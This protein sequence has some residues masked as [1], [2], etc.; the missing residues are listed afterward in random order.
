MPRLSEFLAVRAGTWG[1]EGVYTWRRGWCVQG[2]GELLS[3]WVTRVGVRPVRWP[4][5]SGGDKMWGSLMAVGQDAEL[6]GWGRAVR[7]LG[8]PCPQVAHASP[9]THLLP[10]LPCCGTCVRH[11]YRCPPDLYAFLPGAVS[12]P[13]TPHPPLL[14]S[15]SPHP[16]DSTCCELRTVDCVDSFPAAQ[17]VAPTA[18]HPA[19]TLAHIHHLFAYRHLR[20]RDSLTPYAVSF[21][22]Y[23]CPPPLDAPAPPTYPRSNPTWWTA[24]AP[25]WSAAAG[26][27]G[28]RCSPRA[29]A[30][31]CRG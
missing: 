3:S 6:W 23:A 4:L 27:T 30:P 14:L 12:R 7:C 13:P 24:S 18:S 1:G 10:L 19:P 17:S 5:K 9:V 25:T 16:P 26:A 28:R 8:V 29:G 2:G 15:C 22:T 31:W 20:F 21:A 11:I